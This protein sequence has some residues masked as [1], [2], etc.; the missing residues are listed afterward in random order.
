MDIPKG[1]ECDFGENTFE[2]VSKVHKPKKNFVTVAEKKN[3][4]ADWDRFWR[5]L[6]GLEMT[7]KSEEVCMH[8]W[9]VEEVVDD[10]SDPS[11][12]FGHGQTVRYTKVCTKCG[13]EKEDE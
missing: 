4:Y 5:L 9:E 2:L 7:E 10:Y 13:E 11:D 8:E 1:L 12:Y 3:G 6:R